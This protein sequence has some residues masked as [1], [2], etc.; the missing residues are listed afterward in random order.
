MCVYIIRP[1]LQFVKNVKIVSVRPI[2]MFAV[3]C[4]ILANSL[5]NEKKKVA[6]SEIVCF[7]IHGET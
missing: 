5:C 6:V 1:T 2:Y 3:A 7:A 4:S